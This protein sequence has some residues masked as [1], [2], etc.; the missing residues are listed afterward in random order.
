MADFVK[1][2]LT[3]CKRHRTFA[4]SVCTLFILSVV[5]ISYMHIFLIAWSFVAGVVSTYLILSSNPHLPNL[6][7]MFTR[8]RG[9]TD[10]NETPVQLIRVCSIC[11]DEMCNR[12]RPELTITTLQP[13]S[14]LCIPQ[15]VD[16]AISEILE[17][18]LKNFVYIWYN[19]LGQD[20]QFVTTLRHSLRYAVAVVLRRARKV[21][22]PRLLIDKIFKA[23][24]SHLDCFIKAK[25]GADNRQDIQQLTL[26]KL[27]QHLHCAMT[28][29]KSE[30]QY[31]R[32]MMEALLP[33]IFPRQVLECKSIAALVRE[34]LA[35]SVVLQGMDVIAD[36]DIINKLLLIFFDEEPM[37]V[38][39]DPPSSK[40]C[41]LEGFYEC[42]NKQRNS[43]LHLELTDMLNDKM[44]LYHFMEFMKTEGSLSVL[45]FCL[46]VEDFNR[47]S[48]V[49]ELSQDDMQK[50]HTEA[51]ELYKLYF[52]P[53][54]VDR[55]QFDNDIITEVKSIAEGPFEGVTRL[56]TSDALFRAYE[57]T[58]NLLENTFSPLFHESDA[59]F[60]MLCGKRLSMSQR[61]LSPVSDL[62]PTSP[63]P[64]SSPILPEPDP[65]L[66]L[67][68][69]QQ[70]GRRA[71]EP[72]SAVSKLGSRIKGVFNKTNTADERLLLGSEE[73]LDVEGGQA[74][75]SLEALEGLLPLDVQVRDLSAWRVSIPRFGL[76]QDGNN[77]YFVYVI[78]VDR[79]DIRSGGEDRTSWEVER[80]YNEFYVLES[81]LT[82]FH[83]VF[84]DCTLPSKRS[85]G[86]KTSEFVESKRQVLEKWLQTLLTKRVLRG[87]DLLCNFL[88]TKDEF[89]AKLLPDVNLG[90]MLKS[91]PNRILKE[92]G[93]YLEPF[94]QSFV[95]S[96]EA[97]KPKPKED[98]EGTNKKYPT[99]LERRFNTLYMDN[100]AYSIEDDDIQYTREVEDTNILHLNGV[101]DYILHIA[102]TAYN[103][104]EW[105]HHIF[106]AGGILGKNTLEGFVDYYLGYKIGLALHEEKLELII[107]L[108][109]DA[110]FYDED[111]PRTDEE[112]KERQ[113]ETLMEMKKFIP[114]IFALAVGEE[115][116]HS[117]TKLIFD[118]LQNPKLN[119]QLSYVLLDIVLLE[120]FPELEERTTVN[121]QT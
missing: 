23:G 72:M 79:L 40:V 45:Q 76:R 60:N 42:Q 106:V 116:F 21:D 49:P 25:K 117:G 41:I 10:Q 26:D 1:E 32:K 44:M 97:P 34:V 3:L 9:D 94:L 15:R 11:G 86:T 83:G 66:P 54:A 67:Q 90:K 50:L 43:A 30:L 62:S 13:W 17:L 29:R 19:D 105:F 88:T 38:P 99:L 63:T 46:S 100:A 64:P 71:N 96:T 101:F 4:Y 47:R 113:D 12:H 104:P 111:P 115:Q 103:I 20:E 69:L 118:L 68:Q 48:L 73:D 18:V 57:H 114:K 35:G 85:F 53:D 109:R 110:L 28:S 51:Q 120:L 16:V 121:L 112:K 74:A 87:S 2:L 5:F 33:H 89:V 91:V 7:P 55:I 119:K 80:R 82:E 61:P 14:N 56:R 75:D 22:I 52:A 95:A 70:R 27:E 84:E 102:R 92:R 24:L 37:T 36:P 78:H 65:P 81:K 31:L 98:A 6:L 39:T 107:H 58:Y 59:Y 8:Q 77:R 108:L 93:Q